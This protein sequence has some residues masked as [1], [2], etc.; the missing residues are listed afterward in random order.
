MN[1]DLWH[2]ITLPTFWEGNLFWEGNIYLDTIWLLLTGKH[3]CWSLFL[4]LSIAKFLSKPILKNIYKR[5]L[6]KICSWNWEKLKF[7][8]KDVWFYIKKTGFLNI[9]IRNKFMTGISWLVSHEEINSN[10]EISRVNQKKI[11]RSRKEYVKWTCFKFWPMKN[12]FRKI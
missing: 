6:L 1:T 8:H 10:Y 9:N 4:I 11:K 12:I 3:Q 7:I 5:L 2:K